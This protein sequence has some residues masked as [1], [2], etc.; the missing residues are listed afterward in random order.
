MSRAF[1]LIVHGATGFTG[2][3]VAQYLDQQKVPLRW[4][5][6][7]RN[8]AKL[9]EVRAGLQHKPE[10]LIA[11][12][13][14]PASLSALVAQTQV[15]LSTVGPYAQYGEPLVA[16]CISSG[17]DYVDITGEPAFVDRLLT[18]HGATAK[19]AGVRIVNCCGFDS[20]PHDLGAY[21][22][23]NALP[24]GVP[25]TVEG[26][27]QA[28]G[29]FSGGTWASALGALSHLGEM[30]RARAQRPKVSSARKV[31]SSH[32]RSHYEKRMNG[33]AL[34]LPT[35]DPDVVLRSA[36]ELE[37][38]GPEFRYGHYL[39]ARRLSTAVSVAAGVGSLLVAVQIPPLATWLAK[40]PPAGPGPSPAERAK[41]RFRVVFW[42]QG[43]GQTVRTTIE[44]GD[45]GYDETAKMVAESALA[46]IQ[47]RG[48]LP[49]RT[50]ILTPA[51]AFEAVLVERLA[52]VGLKFEVEQNP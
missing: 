24:R 36:T 9:E 28:K 25:L 19:A 23:V 6:S 26:F 40:R 18:V 34:P 8:R 44:G 43:G 32:P 4:A 7:G 13:S 35:I 27:V 12:A 47:D 21:V 20:I 2:K 37:V 33:W 30:K 46:L 5:I 15:V 17:T 31:G 52:K 42:G 39:L 50:G 48:R 11:D 45:P 16:A 51:S 10:L 3:L 49:A 1:E 22:T 14:D 29:K 41:S 38:Y